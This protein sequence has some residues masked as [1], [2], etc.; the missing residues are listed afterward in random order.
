MFEKVRSFFSRSV[1]S[2][3][4]AATA[5]VGFA[6]SALADPSPLVASTK[7]V[8]ESTAADA[9]TVGGYVVAGVAG[10][11]IIGLIISVIHKLR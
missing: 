4:A 5:V 8:V 7:T 3:S 11:L 9:L 2:V 10:L 1:A 6:G